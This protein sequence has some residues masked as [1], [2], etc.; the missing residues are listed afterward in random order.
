MSLYFIT[1]IIIIIIISLIIIIIIIIAP[2]K[3]TCRWVR[4]N[5]PR[6]RAIF[7]NG[8]TDG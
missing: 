8:R 6:D 3:F 5:V 7:V 1:I 2:A 4:I